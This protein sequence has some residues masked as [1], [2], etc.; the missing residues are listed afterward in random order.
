MS[1]DALPVLMV[2]VPAPTAVTIGGS[3]VESVTTAVLL[4]VQDK[5]VT[6]CPLL[7][8]A[9][10]GRVSPT[11]MLITLGTMENWVPPPKPDGTLKPTALLQTPPCWT[12]TTPLTAPPATDATIC[13]SLQP[14]TSP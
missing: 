8:I 2:A 5:P 12:L 3:S 4:D 7:S 6:S 1:A 9:C 10:I 14:I 13:V 11:I